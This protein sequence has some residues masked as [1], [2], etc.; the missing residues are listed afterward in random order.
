MIVMFRLNWC[1]GWIWSC[2]ISLRE[3]VDLALWG[4]FAKGSDYVS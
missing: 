3:R 1:R 4:R 2:G